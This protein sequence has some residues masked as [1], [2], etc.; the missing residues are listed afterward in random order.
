MQQGRTV[1]GLRRRHPVEPVFEDRGDR[2]VGQ[3]ADLDGTQADCLD[4]GGIQA[5]E[6]TQDAQAGYLLNPGR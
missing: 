2:G 5:A 3:R 1:R 6:Q 4:P